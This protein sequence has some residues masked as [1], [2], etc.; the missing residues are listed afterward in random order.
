MLVLALGGPYMVVYGSYL[1]ADED[2]GA[3]AL[4]TVGGDTAIGLLAGLA[5]FP[6]VFA[7]GLDPSS[8]P[9][10]LFTTLPEVF[11]RVPAAALF[12]AMLFLG[13]AGVAFLSEVAAFEVLVAGLTDNSGLDRTRAVWIMGRWGSSSLSRR[14]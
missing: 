7:L 3:N 12:G 4:W 6:A 2:L 1:D 8:G 11:A 14:R 9:D 10:L 13:L 5:L